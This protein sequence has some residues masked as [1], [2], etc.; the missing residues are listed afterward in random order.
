MKTVLMAIAVVIQDNHLLLRKTDPAK[1]PYSEPW[2]LFGGRIESDGS[3]EEE[4]NNEFKSRWNF[5]AVIIDKLFWNEETKLDH[6]DELKRFIYLDVLCNISEPSEPT[7]TN[8]NEELKWVELSDLSN[9]D[10]NPPSKVL[11]KKL[12]YLS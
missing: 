7:P 11:L 8:P 12:Q 6:D 1:N 10:I 2:A 5:K 3:V 4:M 9:Y